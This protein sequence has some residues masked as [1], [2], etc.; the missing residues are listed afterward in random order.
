MEKLERTEASFKVEGI[1]KQCTSLLC[2]K[3][4]AL[5]KADFRG[6]FSLSNK[7]E[8]IIVWMEYLNNTY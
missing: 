3:L 4:I 7:R 8:V 5:I 1:L 2:D 6:K